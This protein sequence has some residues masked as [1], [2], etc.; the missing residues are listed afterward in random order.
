M[1]K[2]NNPILEQIT[3]PLFDKIKSHHLVPAIQKIIIDNETTIKNIENIQDSEISY[4]F[5]K[6]LSKIDYRLSNAWSQ[7]GHLNSVCNSEEFRVEYNKCKDL[8]TDYYSNISQN[9]KVF[10][11]YVKLKE[12]SLF[13]ELTSIQQKV[14]DNEIRDFKLGGVNL[15]LE[16]QAK[17]KKIQSKLSKL[18]SKFEE[19]VLDETNQYFL[20]IEDSE[21]VRGIPDDVLEQASLLAKED[22]KSGYYFTLHFPS[23]IPV[24]QYAHNRDLR[25]QLYEAYAKKASELS[26]PKYDNSKI[27]QDILFLRSQLANLLGFHNFAELSLDTKM[28]NS[29]I[30]VCDFLKNLASKA[31]PFAEQDYEDLKKYALKDGIK[32]LEAWDV[33]YYSEII[34]QEKYLISDQEIK[35]YFPEHKVIKGLF[36][37]VNK[38]YGIEILESK[39]PSWH[40]SVAY[41]EI[42]QNNKIIGSFYLDL[43]ARKNKRGGAWMDECISKS[44]FN[45]HIDYPVAYLTCN[46]SSPI[47]KNPALFTH[48]EVITLFHEFGHGLHHLLTQVD[49]YNVSGIKG[50]EWDAVELPS[51]FMENFCWNWEVIQNMTEHIKSKETMP[52]NMFDKLIQSKNFQSGMQTVRQVEFALF[53][54]LIHMNDNPINLNVLETLEKVRDAVA[55]VRPP[56]WNRFPHS[57]SHIFAGGYAAGYYSYKWAEVL[58]ADIFDEFLNNGVLNKDIGTRF[59][60]EVLS[61][62][63]S[64]GANESFVKFKGREPTIDALLKHNGLAA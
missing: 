48:D 50:V 61:V 36:D 30:E 46:F 62:G 7:I 27:I 63:G 26:N 3:I 20:H 10:N 38:L 14:I 2:M 49:E 11:L 51:Q 13:A 34:K 64:R 17:Y 53:D 21:R 35:Q 19:N 42:H 9:V 60:K 44:Q 39:A 54:M 55:V 24:L 23:Y 28:A 12:S 25:Q 47:G 33:A 56:K 8:I 52:K 29:P 59:R 15:A 31:K 22:K 6:E 37:L 16:E 43:Y 5:V 57:F 40:S 1:I 4:E 41:Y 32:H 58:S 45:G 18:A